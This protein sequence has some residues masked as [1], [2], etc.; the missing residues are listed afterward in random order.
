VAGI[1]TRRAGLSPTS[2]SRIAALYA[3]RSVAR[4]R[5]SVAADRGRPAGVVPAANSA[6]LDP[7]V[8]AAEHDDAAAIADYRDDPSPL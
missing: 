4:I 1:S 2:P 3:A 6:A 7:S 8:C 5:C